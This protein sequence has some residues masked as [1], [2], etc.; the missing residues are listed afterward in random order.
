[1]LYSFFPAKKVISKSFLKKYTINTEPQVS[2]HPFKNRGEKLFRDTFG[3][4][5]NP[6]RGAGGSP[7][8]EVWV[9]LLRLILDKGRKMDGWRVEGMDGW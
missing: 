6:P 7:E 8:R 9:F 4:P 3:E 2:I 5:Q 1:M